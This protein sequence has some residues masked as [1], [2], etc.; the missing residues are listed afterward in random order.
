[1]CASILS[2]NQKKKYSEKKKFKMANSKKL[3]LSKPPIL[4]ILSKKYRELVVLKISVFLGQPFFFL[5]K[6]CF[7]LIEI[8]HNLCGRIE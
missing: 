7:I 2:P 4:N 1:M 3:S 6:K 8:R 5:K